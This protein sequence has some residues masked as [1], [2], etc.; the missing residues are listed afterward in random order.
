[1]RRHLTVE[2]RRLALRLKAEGLSLREI[3]PQPVASLASGR[4]R[5]TPARLSLRR[6]V[7]R[8]TPA[9]LPVRGGRESTEP[10][11][12]STWACM[13]PSTVHRA[14]AAGAA[15]A[16]FPRSVDP[17]G[18]GQLVGDRVP[19]VAAHHA[20]SSPCGK[21][22]GCRIGAPAELPRGHRLLADW[23]AATDRRTGC[24]IEFPADPMT[25]VRH[26][27]IYQADLELFA[28][29]RH[30]RDSGLE[31]PAAPGGQRR[32]AGSR[33]PGPWSGRCRAGRKRHPGQGV[34]LGR[35]EQL[36]RVPP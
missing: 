2:Q 17:A 5:R 23:R 29:P 21:I 24:R 35:G 8:R 6:S 14:A 31:P 32:P 15:S 36:E 18:G 19:G 34:V 4:R 28:E 20:R 30:A 26:E 11:G 3:G 1:M 9:G 22:P 12:R 27:T 16:A 7:R 10:A 13:P 33:R 25:G